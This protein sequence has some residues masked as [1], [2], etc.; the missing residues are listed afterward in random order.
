MIYMLLGS[1]YFFSG[2]Y[3]ILEGWEWMERNGPAHILM[4]FSLRKNADGNGKT[5]NIY[6]CQQM[7]NL[8]FDTV[9][10]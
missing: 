1:C 10:F 7:S 3:K 2:Y 8:Y 4:Q 6:C 9:L 5:R